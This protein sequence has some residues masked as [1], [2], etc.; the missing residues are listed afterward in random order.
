MKNVILLTL[1]AVR[2]DVFGCYGNKDGLSQLDTAKKAIGAVG[3]LL[4]DVGIPR[5]LRDIG[6]KKE[7]FPHIIDNLFSINMWGVTG[8]PRDCTKEDAL[9]ILEAA[10]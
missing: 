5:R 2:K 4:S 1:D 9:R 7:N 10:W 3:R 6:L 8:N